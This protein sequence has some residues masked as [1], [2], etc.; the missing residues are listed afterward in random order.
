M[1]DRK[2]KT[3]LSVMA[4]S[5][6]GMS[7]GAITPALPEIALAF[8]DAPATFIALVVTIPPLFAVPGSLISGKMI[9]KLAQSFVSS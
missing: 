3:I 1:V 9:G 8:P 5:F 4:M 2:K 6:V 7:K